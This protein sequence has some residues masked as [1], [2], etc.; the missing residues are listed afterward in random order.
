MKWVKYLLLGAAI[1]GPM[2]LR[3]YGYINDTVLYVIFAIVGIILMCFIWNHYKNWRD[4]H[5][6]K[7]TAAQQDFLDK[8][9]KQRD[10]TEENGIKR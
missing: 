7:K 4:E 2:I 8:V 10:K 1:R 6:N 5:S 9:N 3:N